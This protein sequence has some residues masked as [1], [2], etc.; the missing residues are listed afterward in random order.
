MFRHSRRSVLVS[1]AAVVL[2]LVTARVV[3]GDLAALHRQARDAGPAVRVVVATRD[4]LLGEI[5]SEGDLGTR[6]MHVSEVPRGALRTASNGTGRI[7]KV[8]VLEGLPVLQGNLVNRERSGSDGVVPAGM[9]AVQV[10]AEGSLR[11]RPG[12]IVDVLVTFDPARIGAD[13]EPTMTVASG[14]LVIDRPSG[15]AIG[16]SEIHP[17]GNVN[18]SAGSVTVTLVVSIETAHRLAFATANGVVTLAVAP[19]EEA[20]LPDGSS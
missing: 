18:P 16:D 6:R 11:P 5:V 10:S 13:V 4:L 17:E 20:A 15:S 9:R 2:A 3:A 19:P 1:F 8:P 7:V 14:A 12:E